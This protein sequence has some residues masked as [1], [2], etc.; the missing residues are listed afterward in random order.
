MQLLGV[1]RVLQQVHGLLVGG[2]LLFWD[3]P[4][5]KILVSGFVGEEH[6]VIEGVPAAQ[7]VS[8]Y[9]VGEF[10][11]QNHGQAGFV[12]QHVDQPAADNDSVAHAESFQRRSQ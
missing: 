1:G 5:S 6:A 7:V 2:G 4:E 8:Q 9:D 12:R 11:R 3:V 10:V